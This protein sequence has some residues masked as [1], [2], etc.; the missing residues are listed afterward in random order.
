MSDQIETW[1]TH[2]PPYDISSFGYSVSYLS[3]LLSYAL[4]IAKKP[5]FW[6]CGCFRDCNFYQIKLKLVIHLCHHKISV[7]FG[8]LALNLP[9]LLSNAPVNSEKPNGCSGVHNFCRIKLK[10]GIYLYHHKILVHFVIRL[11]IFHGLW[12]MPLHV[13]NICCFFLKWLNIDYNCSF[14][15]PG[16]WINQ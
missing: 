10:L 14:G 8:I 1:Y 12:V 5:L 3:W 9:W 16:A 11:R 2:I 13:N 15:F 6:A 4:W 7:P